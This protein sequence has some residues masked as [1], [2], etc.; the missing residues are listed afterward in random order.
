MKHLKAIVVAIIPKALK[1][2]GTGYSINS[3]MKC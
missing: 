3:S 2:L 1:Q